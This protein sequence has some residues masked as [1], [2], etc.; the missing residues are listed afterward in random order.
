MDQTL[1]TQFRQITESIGATL[2]EIWLAI[3]AVLLLLIDLIGRDKVGRWLPAITVGFLAVNLVLLLQQ[4]LEPVPN[5]GQ[6]YFGMLRLDAWGLSLKYVFNLA[7]LFTVWLSVYSPEMFGGQMD[8]TGNGQG[9][10]YVFLLAMLAGMQ[11]LAMA[12]HLLMMYVAL[13]TVSIGG[14]VLALFGFGR[15]SVEAGMKYVLFGVF[16]SA[17]MLYGMS[18]LYGFSGSLA[19]TEILAKTTGVPPVALLAALLLTF[20]GFL[21]KTATVPFHLWAPDV[22]E[23]APVPVVAFLASAPKAAGFAVLFR[24]VTAYLPTPLLLE[25]LAVIALATITIGNLAALGQTSAKRLLAYSS[26][27]H[28]GFILIGILTQTVPGTFYYLLAYSISN[29]IAFG[30][31]AAVC[32]QLGSDQLDAFKGL[33]QL[34]PLAGVA[35][36]I[37]MAALIGLPPTAGFMAKLLIFSALWESWQATNNVSLL[38]LLLGGLLNTVISV[39]YYLKIPFYM[40]LRPPV[41]SAQ[42]LRLSVGQQLFLGLAAALL[43]GLFVATGQVLAWLAL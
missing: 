41:A 38:A 21:F 30:F 15:K 16:S 36:L 29:F 40:F 43:I 1:T 42:I 19:L 37:S 39:Y 11:L 2:P 33:G 28:A 26:I 5:P 14:Y 13:E 31:I 22:Y 8:R 24:L 7:S 32:R 4:S 10:F 27:A 6:A 25:T 17:V 23:A 3:A 34:S 18:L 20:A 35:V 12:D 9:E